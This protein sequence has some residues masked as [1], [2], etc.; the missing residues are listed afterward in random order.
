MGKVERQAKIGQIEKVLGAK[1]LCFVT[2][3]RPGVEAPANYITRDC[4]KIVEQHLSVTEQHDTLALYLVSHGGDID[5]PWP[6][7]NLLRGHC[8]KLQ[9]VIPYICHSA[10]T[11][12]ALGCDELVAGPRAQLSPTDPMLTVRTSTDENAPVMQFGVED[13]NAFVR[14]AQTNL[15]RQFSRH[16]HEAL[17][18]TD[19]ESE[20]RAAGFCEQNVFPQQ[21]ANRKDARSCK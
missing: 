3:D 11:Q 12:I 2:S 18:Q 4:V 21:T 19:R 7:V 1:V 6:L 20:A 17:I 10:A 13:I 9:V 5:V 15:G 14:F 8:E 16:G